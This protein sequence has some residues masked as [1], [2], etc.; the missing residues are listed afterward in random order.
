MSITS[1]QPTVLPLIWDSTLSWPLKIITHKIRTLAESFFGYLTR[2]VTFQL[3]EMKDHTAYY[4]MRFYQLLISCDPK[5]EKPVDLG[6][7]NQSKALLIRY[8][9]VESIVEAIGSHVHLI[10]FKSADFFQRFGTPIEITHEGRTRRAVI[11]PPLEDAKK[12]YFPIISIQMPDGSIKKGALLP[13]KSAAIDP[14]HI[15]HCHSPGRSMSMDR[16]FIGMHLAAGYDVTVWDPRGTIDSTGIASEGGYYLD[17]EAV[18]G[19]LR[20]QNIAPNK[21]YVSGF[22]EGA[23]IAAHLKQKYHDEGVHFI[24]SNPY[25]SMSDV[26]ANHGF[27]GRLGINY[28]LHAL[29]DPTL[30]VEQ[31]GF[32]NVNKMKNLPES[33]GKCI[34]IH[35]DTD[36]M[37]PKGT[38]AKLIDAFNHAGPVHE[39]L[40]I[41]PNP[42]ENGHLQPPYED[43]QV[44]RRYIQVVV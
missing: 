43:P 1:L 12:F 37:M 41:H 36:E 11:D 31:D 15:L 42:K 30:P 4:I 22:C 19:F 3:G 18:Y 16:K 35:T 32:D 39:I 2:I 6:R 24:A 25:T 27:L 20:N 40:R 33:Q 28:G 14:P 26:F 21:I 23:A 29:K 9:G 13:E 38:V 17:A 10:S 5:D 34:F 44:W 8:G 7:L